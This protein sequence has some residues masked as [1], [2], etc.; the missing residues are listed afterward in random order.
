MI[1]AATGTALL[2]FTRSASAE[3]RVKALLPQRNRAQQLAGIMNSRTITLAKATAL[4]LFV[5]DE[6]SQTG[7]NFG[8][9]LHA[10]F[11]Q[12]F[13]EGFDKV[14]AIGNDC[15]ALTV[16]LIRYAQ[17]RL[18]SADMVL[19]PSVDGGVYLLGLNKNCFYN[20]DFN[21]LPWQTEALFTRLQ[22]SAPGKIIA[23]DLPCLDDIDTYADLR[24][25]FLQGALPGWLL[26]VV[27][28]LLFLGLPIWVSTFAQKSN[29]FLLNRRLRAPPRYSFR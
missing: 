14:I 5:V 6:K 20:L 18:E 13:S 12:V 8:S 17:D 28:R 19:G 29:P 1:S 24:Q 4:P 26:G 16:D 21:A 25:L 3:A 23:T 9:R 22:Q 2:F 10:A 11:A 7:A 27:A 15:P